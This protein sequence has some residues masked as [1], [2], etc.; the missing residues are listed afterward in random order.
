MFNF[1]A[2]RR[3]ISL[4]SPKPFN[5]AMT[6]IV[7]S[8]RH[9]NYS[10]HMTEVRR[11]SVF[12]KWL[13]DLRDRRAVARIVARIDRLAAGNPG[14][15]EPVGNG[16]S[17]LKINY[18]PGYRAYYVEHGLEIIVLLCGGDKSSQRRDI[19]KAKELAKLLKG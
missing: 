7:D 5:A 19:K 18:G 10:Y 9:D 14:V 13:S 17:E 12:N 1:F 15:V 4:T 8:K 2:P 16:I 11:S 3:V 6:T